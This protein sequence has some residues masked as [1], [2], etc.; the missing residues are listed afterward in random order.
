MRRLVVSICLG[1]LLA[2]AGGR[3][4]AAQNLIPWR[5]GAVQPKGDAGFWYM[6]AEGGFAKQQGLDMKML[7][8]N[9]D[10]LLLKA[11]IAGCLLYTSPSPRD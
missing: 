2:C 4:V 9:S 5:H 11:L 10:V 7:A 6:A 3:T 8:L 1:L